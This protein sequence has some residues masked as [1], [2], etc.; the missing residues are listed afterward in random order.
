MKTII[1]ECVDIMMTSNNLDTRSLAEIESENDMLLAEIMSKLKGCNG[2][3]EDINN[4]LR[5]CYE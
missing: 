5:N 2:I 3:I 1:V 4:N